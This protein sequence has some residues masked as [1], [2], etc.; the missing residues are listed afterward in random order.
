MYPTFKK[1]NEINS[2][3]FSENDDDKFC[4]L[5]FTYCDKKYPLNAL[6]SQDLKK[7]ILFAKKIEKKKWRQ[8]KYEDQGFNYE[9]PSKFNVNI[10]DDI[11]RDVT[12]I[13]LRVNQKFRIIGFRAENILYIIWFDKNHNSYDG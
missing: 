5:K 10:P 7:F 4:V 12:V 11:P 1:P 6:S 9:T 8:I 13:S 3:N 2:L